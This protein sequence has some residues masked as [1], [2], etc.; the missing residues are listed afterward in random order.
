MIRPDDIDPKVEQVWRKYLTEGF[1]DQIRMRRFFRRLPTNPRCK[2]CYAPFEGFGGALMHVL[3]HKQRSSHNPQLCNVCERFATQFPG[4][5]E[6]ELSMLF[7]DIRGSTTLAEKMSPLSFSQLI[8]RFY[9]ASV[10]VLARSG[11]VIDRLAGDQMIG[12]FVPGIIG[13]EHPRIAVETALD[14][15]TATGYA[16]NR[17]PWVSIGIGVHTGIAFFGAVGKSEG[18]IDITALGDAVNTTARLASLAGS[19]EVLVS[20]A[21]FRAAKLDRNDLESRSLTLKGRDQPIDVRVIR[22]YSTS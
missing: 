12:Y 13:N 7:A 14:L 5:A 11:A 3:Y 21:A 1:P 9:N 16:I 19:G 17:E 22:P 10:D 2:N 6:V 8:N 4:G 20:E 18:I 15:L